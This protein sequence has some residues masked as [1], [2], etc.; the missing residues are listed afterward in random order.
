MIQVSQSLELDLAVY[1]KPD[2]TMNTSCAVLED[3][4]VTWDVKMVFTGI[5]VLNPSF[6]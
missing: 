1:V 4:V 5:R 6:C 3:P 2:T